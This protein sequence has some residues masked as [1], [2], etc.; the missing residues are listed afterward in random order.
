MNISISKAE[1]RRRS[2]WIRHGSRRTRKLRTQEAQDALMHAA[3]LAF[4]DLNH[5]NDLRT[6]MEKQFKRMEKLFGYDVGSWARGG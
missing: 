1:E 4:D 3:Q 6:A 2:L 5:D